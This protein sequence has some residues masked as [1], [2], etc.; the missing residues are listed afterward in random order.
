MS[1][2]EICRLRV[3][4]RT[5]HGLARVVDDVS[6]TLEPRTNFG[7]VG[8]SGCGKTTLAKAILRLLPENAVIPEGQILLNGRDLLT[9]SETE[10]R[11]VRW[12]EIALIPQ[13]AL[14]ALDPVHSVGSQVV[15][16]ILA[17][18]D[19]PSLEA[20]ARARALFHLVGLDAARFDHYPHQF[21]GGMRQ[22]V[23]IAMALALQPT[24]V[25]ADEPTTALDILMQNQIL[26]RIRELQD[27]LG[28]TILLI[29][30]DMGVV[31]AMCDT[32]GVMYAGRIVE[33][34]PLREVFD[35]PQHPY[36]WGLL[37]AFPALRVRRTAVSIPGAPPSPL[38]QP[39]GCR[40]HPRC[41][42][43][44]E[45]CWA[46]VPPLRLVRPHGLVACHFAETLQETMAK[47]DSQ[48]VWDGVLSRG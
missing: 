36:T 35:R 18:E 33:L 45:R 14:N 27:E 4:F 38:T 42:F 44:V 30:H 20:Q 11:E 21:S 19:V 23:V 41:P 2:L 5:V 43:A 8:E 17:H 16:A 32:V 13:S 9:I 10:L 48:A 26:K 39:D 22:R 40:F 7:L 6:L 37:N 24:L 47:A 28:L 3:F 12:K 34:G 31:A 29:T 1:L 25:I 15:E 46:E